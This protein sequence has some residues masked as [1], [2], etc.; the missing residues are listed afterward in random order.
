M[1]GFNAQAKRFALLLALI[2]TNSSAYE[3][4][5]PIGFPTPLVPADNPMT[6]A[7]V[8]LGSK[9]FADPRLSRNGHVSC[10]SCHDPQ[11][12]FSD[13]R[14][15]SIGALGDELPL[16]S[17]SLWNV[18]YYSSLGW[19][20]TGKRTLEAQHVLPLTNETPVEMGLQPAQ[21]AA[22]WQD[23][24][25]QSEVRQAFGDVE[26]LRLEHLTYA[27]ASYL[28]TLVR[29][30]TAF[31]RYLF[32]DDAAALNPQQ[33]EG[34]ELF[35]SPRLNCTACHRGS[36]LSGPTASETAV[37][38]PTFYAT[39]I[40]S[41]DEAFRA[42]SL[43]FVSETAPYM[44]DG[45]MSTLSQVIRFYENGGGQNAQHLQPFTLTERQREALIAFLLSL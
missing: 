45:S 21:I 9:L 41:S 12:A 29:A 17:P 25:L 16:N 40:S 44:H 3:W 15:R 4:Q 30:G 19:T 13:P 39:G 10:A 37:H 35:L 38:E 33:R 32:E 42:P 27:I 5:L 6:E 11:R 22:L 8:R 2:A 36:L 18:A 14:T 43:R 23:A 34:L 7:K 24:T 28:R 26:T 20:D 1:R 31:D